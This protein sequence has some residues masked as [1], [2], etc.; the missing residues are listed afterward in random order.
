MEVFP[1]VPLS[2]SPGYKGQT[3]SVFQ[4]LLLQLLVLKSLWTFVQLL[5]RSFN[6]EV[7]EGI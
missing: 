3:R 4:H 5:P 6:E 1:P 7:I 2:V